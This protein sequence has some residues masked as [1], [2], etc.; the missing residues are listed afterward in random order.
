MSCRR[1]STPVAVAFAAAGG[2]SSS[3]EAAGCASPDSDTAATANAAKL[4][5]D[6]LMFSPPCTNSGDLRAASLSHSECTAGPH[7]PPNGSIEPARMTP[8]T[9]GTP[10]APLVA[11]PPADPPTP[12]RP[13]GTA[14]W[15]AR[16]GRAGA[17]LLRSRPGDPGWAR[18]ALLLLLTATGV[19]YLWGLGASGWANSFYSAAAQAGSVSWK[20]FFYG[21]SDAANSITVDKTPASVWVMALSAR[22]FGVNAWS[23]LVPQALM[24][25]GTVGVLYGTVRRWFSPGAA[26]LSGAVLA[27]TPVAAL[28]FRFNNPDALLTLLL[29]LGGYATVR[30]LEQASTRWLVVAAACVGFGFM[31]KM[32]QALL[33]VPAFAVAYLLAAPAPARRRVRQVLLAGLGL[34]VSAGWWVAVVELVPAAYRPY[35]GGSQ[36][37]SILELAL[38]Y[39]GLGR[40]TGNETGSVGGQIAWLLPAALILLAAGLW[41]TR[42]APRTDRVRAAFVLWGGWLL[43]TVAAFS[44]MQGI[45]HPYYTV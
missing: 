45:F 39:N 37:N 41:F 29:T 4:D 7:R 20:A 26:L 23:I 27:V 40:L 3:V 18:P 17:R 12:D 25:V 34:L 33:V 6:V 8:T 38:G 1:S 30:A 15:Q 16:V 44:Q 5:L 43:V 42:R 36:T 22:I 31:T 32:L 24:G 2:W 21:S 28:M 35:I 11:G 10:A 9:T 14:A 19:L 13:P